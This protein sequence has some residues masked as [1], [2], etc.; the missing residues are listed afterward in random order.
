MKNKNIFIIVFVFLFILGGYFIISSLPK[1]TENTTTT[2]DLGENDSVLV[3]QLKYLYNLSVEADS[4]DG[5]YEEWIEAVNGP[6]EVIGDTRKDVR[7]QVIGEYIQ[8]QYIEDENWNNL[9]ALTDLI[10]DKQEDE[11][12]TN[13]EINSQGELVI[14]FSNNETENIGQVLNIYTVKFKDYNGYLLDVQV[15]CYGQ[16]ATEP[17]TPTREGYTFT[18]W[19]VDFSNVTTNLELTATYEINQYDVVFKD[20][21]DSIIETQ[22]I[23]H[24]E[25]VVEPMVPN[26][27]GYYF[28]G[29]SVDF[30]NV[31]SDLE[32]YANYEAIIYTVTFKGFDDTVL[33]TQLVSPNEAATAPIAPNIVGYTFTG[34]DTDFTSVES[35]LV[36]KALYNVNSYTISFNS[37][38]GNDINSIT[39]NYNEDLGDLPTPTLSAHIFIGW[40]TDEAF[41]TEFTDTKMPVDGAI[42]YAKWEAITYLINFD[43]TGGD[44]IESIEVEY[45]ENISD[46]PTP[47]KTNYLFEGWYLNDVQVTTFDFTYSEDITLVAKWVGLVN[48]LLFTDNGTEVSIEGYIGF[49]TE[50]VIPDSVSGLNITKIAQGAFKNNQD[51]TSI[52][53]GEY[54]T[55]IEDQAFYGMSELTYIALPA[56]AKIIGSDLLTGASKLETIVV[57]S[58]ATYNLAYYFGNDSNNI[59]DTLSLVKYAS[60]SLSVDRA[61]FTGNLKNAALELADD[62]LSIAP[63]MFWGLTNITKIIIPSSVTSIGDSAFYLASNL[64]EV[65]FKE[66]SQLTT[67]G[68]HA[69]YQCSSLV[70]ITIPNSVITIGEYAFNRTT[71]LETIT[72]EANSQLTTIDDYAFQMAGVV[73]KVTIPNSVTFI[74]FSAFSLNNSLTEVNFEENSQLEHIDDY[75]FSNDDGLTSFVIPNSVTFIG[76][77]AFRGSDKIKMIILPNSVNTIETSAFEYCSD[78]TIY[79][80][81]TS[82]QSGWVAGWNNSNRPVVFGMLGFGSTSNF[83]YVINSDNTVTITGL[84]LSNTSTDLIIPETIEGLAVTKIQELAFNRSTSFNTIVIPDTIITIGVDAFAFY[85]GT[86]YAVPTTRPIGWD[87][88]CFAFN[89]VVVWGYTAG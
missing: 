64:T 72:F 22:T 42:L 44:S 45:L 2:M 55:N 38:G 12:I 78:L 7:F 79:T 17:D 88:N 21:D 23:T 30:S 13:S 47:V 76:E 75:A 14:T 48:G 65:T 10:K 62:C 3:K 59:P 60:G 26:R 81:F 73:S 85:I 18:G 1:E 74:G 8:W 15:L 28:V 9:V 36:V 49:D 70:N 77:G 25:Q 89:T 4:F 56:N 58:E 87:N 29:W 84:A 69:F 61:L 66:G 82:V 83:N 40:Y 54:I 20:F 39:L 80:E 16:S 52:T 68:N 63:N 11:S 33:D 27:D 57:S 86:V 24:G 37:N 50:I 31:T 43:T 53:L 67:I 35:H 41:E 5:T 71:S 51:I 6:K 19:D 46:L 34:W 32:V